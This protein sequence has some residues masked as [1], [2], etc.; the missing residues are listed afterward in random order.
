M[1]YIQTLF[2]GVTDTQTVSEQNCSPRLTVVL[3]DFQTSISNKQGQKSVRSCYF[4][5]RNSVPI[6]T[7]LDA[8]SF[9]F[10]FNVSRFLNEDRNR[11][12][13]RWGVGTGEGQGVGKV[14][15]THRGGTLKSSCQFHHLQPAIASCFVISV[16]ERRLQTAKPSLPPQ[17]PLEAQPI[18][19]RSGSV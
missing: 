14:G 2:C 13:K 3:P 17:S 10:S 11:Y 1:L 7:A 15:G 4:I 19:S 8:S 18:K 16:T 6:N 9:R 12:Y 5:F